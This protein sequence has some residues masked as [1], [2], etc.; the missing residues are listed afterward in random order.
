MKKTV[1]V[2]LSL[3][4]IVSLASCTGSGD[5]SK[6]NGP[7]SVADV[8]AGLVS[9]GVETAANIAASDVTDP[10]SQIEDDVTY[11]SVDIDLTSLSSTMVYSEVYDMMN[12][13]EQFE[14]KIIRMRGAF[15]V[16]E[17]NDRNYYACIIADATAC[18]Q[19]GLE[20][21]RVGDPQYPSQYPELGSEITVVG[22]FGTYTEGDFVYCE[23]RNAEMTLS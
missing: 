6:N 1:Y 3:V 2:L 13:P 12:D 22:V 7:K 16:Y 10:S 23:L 15:A 21:V 17:G 9:E 5:T 11:D 20:F 4:L 18:C 19:Q 8:V 14:G